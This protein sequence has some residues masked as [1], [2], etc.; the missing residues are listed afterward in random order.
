[1]TPEEEFAARSLLKW[2]RVNALEWVLLY[3]RRRIG[4]VISDKEWPGMWRSIMPD[5]TLS[6]TAN[7]SWSKDAVLAQAVREVAYELSCKRPA[8]SQ[9]ITGSFRQKSSPID[10]NAEEAV[11]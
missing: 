6:D 2:Q 8:K 10:L 9:Q 1:M 4:R 5:G 11:A 3:R 7:L